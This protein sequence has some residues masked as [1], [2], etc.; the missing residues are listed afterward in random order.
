[1]ER[2]IGELVML[3][4]D[5]LNTKTATLLRQYCKS[6]FEKAFDQIYG[7]LILSALKSYGVGPDYI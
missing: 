2:T 6:D 7:M 5:I 4:N 1:M 3:I